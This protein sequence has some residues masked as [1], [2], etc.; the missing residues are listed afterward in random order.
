M[1]AGTN[2]A[3]AGSGSQ[4]QTVAGAPELLMGE[5]AVIKALSNGKFEIVA[6]IRSEEWEALKQH[7]GGL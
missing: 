1:P 6:R 3:I 4:F 2:H 7:Q 5:C